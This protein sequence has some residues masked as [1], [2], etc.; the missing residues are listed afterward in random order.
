MQSPA[1]T[2]PENKC[3]DCLFLQ[4]TGTPVES[5]QWFRRKLE[6]IEQIELKI[7]LNFNEQWEPLPA[8][9][10]KFGI[11]AGELRLLLNNGKIPYEARELNDMLEL[12]IPIERQQQSIGK[13]KGGGKASF[14]SSGEVKAEATASLETTEGT[15]DKF[16]MS[17]TQVT[18]KGLES[19]PAWVFEVKTGEPVLKGTI[20]DTKLATVVVER[21][22]CAIEATF[23]VSDRDVY[24]SG[25]EGLWSPDI[26]RNKKAVIE[27]LIILRSLK[28]R[29]KPYLS[30]QELQY[31]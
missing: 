21:K 30:R 31:D 11:K 22:P 16:Q 9:R 7:T 10:I 20:S 8:G 24:V 26:S 6:Q 1:Q 19:N 2:E 28:S 4:L 29:L 17:V 5:R 27:R 13:E 25:G 3:P 12:S 14:A 18:T 23:E 15:T